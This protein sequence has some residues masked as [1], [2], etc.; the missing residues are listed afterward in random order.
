MSITIKPSVD[1]VSRLN[2]LV[3]TA[4][5]FKWFGDLAIQDPREAQAP[6]FAA[7]L[8]LSGIALN[9]TAQ[10]EGEA[11]AQLSGIFASPWQPKKERINE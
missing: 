1:E 9:A 7:A 3:K 2:D 4:E 6:G 5:A 8:H 10:K 11:L